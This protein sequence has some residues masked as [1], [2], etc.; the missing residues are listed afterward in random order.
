MT[1]S[2]G[3]RVAGVWGW[4]FTLLLLLS[5]GMASVPGGSDADSVVRAFYTAHGGVVITAQVIGLAA[6]AAFAVFALTLR[7]RDSGLRRDLGRLE[8]AGLAVAVASVL[9]VVPPLW[10]TFVA[11]DASRTAVHRLAVA[12]DLVDVVLF[13]AI[14]AFAGV[15]A[16]AASATWV[17][18]LSAL[19]AVLAAARALSLLLGSEWL[20]LVAPLAFIAL[21]VVASTLLLLGRPPV[22]PR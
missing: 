17:T 2:G 10:L 6:S 7:Q 22:P 16:A 15:L 14:G 8:V 21:V 4:T 1:A 20:E 19:V 5:A 3:G 12:S 11:D 13:V 18:V 9:T